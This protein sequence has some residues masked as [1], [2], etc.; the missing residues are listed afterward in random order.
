MQLGNSGAACTQEN[1]GAIRYDNST[2]PGL[3]KVCSQP[4]QWTVLGA[5]HQ[6]G[7]MY[8][9]VAEDI[10]PATS[11]SAHP[12]M[13]GASCLNPNPLT[14]NTCGCPG[15]APNDVNLSTVG[16]PQEPGSH[17]VHDAIQTHYC[18]N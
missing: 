1:L 11:E 6:F 10:N 4:P 7:G 15:W 3:V 9:L 5:Q 14:N 18:Y 2:I 16:T 13:L 12:T 8:T 17:N